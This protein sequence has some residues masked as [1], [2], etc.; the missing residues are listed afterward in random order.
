M[1]WHKT[2][3]STS[4]TCAIS[5]LLRSR[6]PNFALIIEEVVSTLLRLIVRLKPILVVSV[7]VAEIRP[8]TEQAVCVWRMIN[9]GHGL[10]WDTASPK[11]TI[12]KN[13]KPTT[14][15]RIAV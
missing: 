1:L 15:F 7:E 4:L 8:T 12:A 6:P 13:T 9:S 2:L 3:Q 5:A 14:A 10:A 11:I